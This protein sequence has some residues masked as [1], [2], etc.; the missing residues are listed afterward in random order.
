VLVLDQDRDGGEL[1]RT[2][3]QQRGAIV[4]T[5]ATVGD[6][7]E[8][9]EAWRPDVLVSDALSPEHDS[10]ALIGKVR[11]LDADQGGRIPALALT[12]AARTDQRLKELIGQLQSELPKPVEPSV[13]TSEIAR[14]TGRERRRAQRR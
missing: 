10:Y 6:A 14:L 2:V 11:S 9:L 7:L 13:L 4:R 12:A 3:L 1:L 5:V 8:A